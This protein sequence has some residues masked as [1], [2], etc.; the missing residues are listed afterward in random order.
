MGPRLQED[1]NILVFFKNGANLEATSI[2][3]SEKILKSCQGDRFVSFYLVS[4][5]KYLLSLNKHL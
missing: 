1:V 2:L 4:L 5:F 3:V